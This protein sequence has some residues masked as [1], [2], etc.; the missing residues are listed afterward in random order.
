MNIC[1]L[2]VHAKPE[3]AAVVQASLERFPGVEIHGGQSEGKLI[4]SVESDGDEESAANT[5]AAFRDVEGVINTVLIY[6]YGEHDKPTEELP[7][8]TIQKRIYQE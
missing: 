7:S 3:N 2:V 6:H 8:E 1:S 5:M 4:V